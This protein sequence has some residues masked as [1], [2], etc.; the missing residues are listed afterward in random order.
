MSNTDTEGGGRPVEAEFREYAKGRLPQQKHRDVYKW[1]GL[2][3]DPQ[4]AEHLAFCEVVYEPQAGMPDE[5]VETRYCEDFVRKFGTETATAALANQNLPQLAYYSGVVSNGL[6]ASAFPLLQTIKRLYKPDDPNHMLNLVWTAPPPPEG[7]TGVGKTNAAYTL[8]EGIQ[9][10]KPE[11]KI[12]TNNASDPF[13]SIHSWTEFV[14]WL[15]ETD[16]RKLFYLDEAAQV[17]QYKDQSD[18][19]K[20]SHM[21]KLGRH[22]QC[23]LIFTAHTGIDV[24]KD[25][26]RMVL[27]AQKQSQKSVKIGA[28]LY[29]TPTGWMVIKNVLYE[30]DKL[31]PTTIEYQSIG[32]TGRFTFDD[33]TE[34]TELETADSEGIDITKYEAVID[35][36]AGDDGL[37]PVSERYEVSYEQ[38]RTWVNEF[39][40]DQ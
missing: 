15:K 12:A 38:L 5:F 13:E 39:T 6:D 2:I 4:I 23:D 30:I 22:Y 33:E 24:P 3:R 34:G 8:I 32:D 37:R 19:L 21:I 26:R 25:L 27:F 11:V 36:L 9:L 28:G 10:I 18:G 35:Y 17:L 31:P 16:G 1:A 40:G 29:E 20:V 14:Q 7:P